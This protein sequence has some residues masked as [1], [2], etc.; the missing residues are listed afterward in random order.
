MV[1]LEF[2]SNAAALEF[3]QTYNG[4]AY[5]SLEPE[6]VCHAVWVSEIERGEDGVPMGI[7]SCRHAQ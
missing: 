1:L 6:S 2:R 5:N 7:P 4:A 3:Y